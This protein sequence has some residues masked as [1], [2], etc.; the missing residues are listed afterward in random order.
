MISGVNLPDILLVSTSPYRRGLMERLQ[1]PFR[2][3]AP[4]FDENHRAYDD[5]REMVLELSRG[6]AM[7]V[8]A[9]FTDAILIGSDQIV[10]FDGKPVGKPLSQEGALRQLQ[11]LRGKDHEFYTGLYLYD[12]RRRESQEFCIVGYGRLRADLSDEELRSYIELDDPLNSAGG[13]KTE[14]MGLMLFD[15]LECED[16]TA[17]VGLPVMA[18]A[19][20]LRKWG[21]RLFQRYSIG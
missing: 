14:G 7:S 10:W 16:W 1:M 21:Y 12:C 13:V 11:S 15:K 6:K 9:D 4:R 19:S 3:A 17:I 18:L 8:A 5:P 2:V 20:G